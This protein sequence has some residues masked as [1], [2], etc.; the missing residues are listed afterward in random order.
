MLNTSVTPFTLDY[1]QILEYVELC[2]T[3][4]DLT[5]WGKMLMEQFSKDFFGKQNIG[6]N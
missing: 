4:I 1:Y 5:Y 2:K 3:Q 6:K